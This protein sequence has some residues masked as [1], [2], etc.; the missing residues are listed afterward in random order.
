MATIKRYE[1]SI[2]RKFHDS[3]GLGEVIAFTGKME[4]GLTM[5]LMMK[6]A[7]V[8]IG[9]DLKFT[10]DGWCRRRSDRSAF[11]RLMKVL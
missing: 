7:N 2:W 3:S 10:L 5:Y 4:H 1:D 6:V 11:S 8:A 9:M